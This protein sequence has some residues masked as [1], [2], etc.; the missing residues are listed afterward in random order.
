VGYSPSELLKKRQI[1]TKID[2][3]LPSP[4]CDAQ[5]QQSKQA[6]NL[7]RPWRPWS[8]KMLVTLVLLFTLGPNEIKTQNAGLGV[9]TFVWSPKVQFGDVTPINYYQGT[10]PPSTKNLEKFRIGKR[11][12]DIEVCCNFH[13]ERGCVYLARRWR[14]SVPEAPSARYDRLGTSAH[15]RENPRRTQRQHKSSKLLLNSTRL[16]INLTEGVVVLSKIII[17][18]Q[19]VRD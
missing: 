18:S 3:L 9:S 13:G 6:V 14:R 4:V 12:L 17:S 7:N 5:S 11:D 19:S 8:L 16:G 10:R 15:S 1:R 2:T